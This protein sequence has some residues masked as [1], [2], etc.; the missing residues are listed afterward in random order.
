M[1]KAA[2]VIP[3]YGQ[4][5]PGGAEAEC[6][7]TA[8][9]LAARGNRV[10][11]LTTCLKS[12]GDSWEADYHPPGVKEENGVIVRRF[13][14]DKRNAA[15]F[16][17]LNRRLLSGGRLRLFQELAFLNNMVNSTD[18]YRAIAHIHDAVLFPIPYLFS[19]TWRTALLAPDSCFPIA[20]LHDEGYAYLAPLAAA[21]RKCKGLIFH[22]FSEMKLARRAWRTGSEQAYLFGEGIDT[23]CLG[24]A[25]SFR[26][27]YHIKEPFVLYA[28][29]KDTTKNTPFLIDCFSAY[30]QAE[31]AGNRLKLVLVGDQEVV[32]PP[33]LENEIIDL[34]FVS[35][36]DK[37][38]AFAAAE[39]FCQPSLNESFSIVIM[40]AWLNR[41]P[42]LVHRGCGP[43]R[44]HVEASGGG[45]TFTDAE[46]FRAAVNTSLTNPG[47]AFNRAESGRRY[48]LENFSWDP[49]CERYE[50]LLDRQW[51]IDQKASMGA[52]PGPDRGAVLQ[53]EAEPQVSVSPTRQLVRTPKETTRIHQI[54]NNLSPGDAIGHDVMNIRTR[55]RQAGF[56]SEIFCLH[57]GP[58]M[59]KEARSA[60]DYARFSSPTNLIIWHFSIGTPLFELLSPLPDRVVMR[61]HNIT[62]FRMFTGISPQLE[63]E[64]R[65]GRYQLAQAASFVDLGI[66]VSKFNTGELENLGYSN[67]GDC[68]ILMDA[69][70]VFGHLTLGTAPG[71][72][73]EP[74]RI[75]HVGRLMPQKRYEDLIRSFAFVEKLEPGSRL[76]LVG[77]DEGLEVYRQGLERL[78]AELGLSGVEFRGKIPQAELVELYHTSD[79]YLCLSDHE[80]FCVPLMEAMAAGLPIIAK[81]SAAIPETM[82]GA[83][84]VLEDPAPSLVAETIWALHGSRSYRARVVETQTRRLADFDLDRT[85]SRMSG[86]LARLV[87]VQ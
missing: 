64:C 71:E 67:T 14:I 9:N 24:D 85:W 86:L 36:E 7:R 43:T 21:Y 39:V 33:G 51:A 82:G 4:E 77:G 47:W 35:R 6:R 60:L 23:D 37:E 68:P 49:V 55:L 20:C 62:P 50:A 1:R 81:A 25:T 75:L 31:G 48:V 78:V 12:H 69:R 42:V 84:I 16:D 30:K 5:I 73:D 38:N 70:Q 56:Q 34:G 3:W 22:T 58:G 76:I 27:K 63:R 46:S 19:T 79:V 2:F 15:L 45:W 52:A 10:E 18:L 80:G 26:A 66:G 8:E 29:R 41:T 61:Y 83:G 40:E 44:D 87:E 65:L 72:S 17:D 53:A 74:P 59:A 54:V 13:P 28:G 32:V 57:A 11:V